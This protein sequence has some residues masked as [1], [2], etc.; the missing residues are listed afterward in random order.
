MRRSTAPDDKM[1]TPIDNLLFWCCRL[2]HRI[3]KAARFSDA[4]MDAL[5]KIDFWEQE[6]ELRQ[7]YLVAMRLRAAWSVRASM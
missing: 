4:E 3:N 6:E 5:E 1:D 7:A 2:V